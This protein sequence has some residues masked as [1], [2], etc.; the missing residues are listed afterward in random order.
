MISRLLGLLVRVL[1][2]TACLLLVAGFLLAVF[3]YR[4]SRRLVVQRPDRVER[5]VPAGVAFAQAAGALVDAL[6]LRPVNR[7]GS[8]V[9]ERGA[10]RD[11]G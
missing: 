10:D 9:D 1:L 4:L 11:A 5:L 8:T 7:V 3:G 6:G 2:E